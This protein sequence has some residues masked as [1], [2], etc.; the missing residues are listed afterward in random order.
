MAGE[1]REAAG[2]KAR[3]GDEDGSTERSRRRCAC[4]GFR[5]SAAAGRRAE[6]RRK[7]TV[8]RSIVEKTMTVLRL[9]MVER[10]G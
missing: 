3:S 4:L 9:A 2:Q 5:E 7:E 6:V 1:G 8:E 10:S